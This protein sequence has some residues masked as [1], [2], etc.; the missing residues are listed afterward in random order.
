MRSNDLEYKSIAK[1]CDSVSFE[2]QI[3]TKTS[4]NP[5]KC[6]VLDDLLSI[7]TDT[8]TTMYKCHFNYL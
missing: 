7:L 8:H 5:F 6:Q 4:H 1:H 3:V 2:H